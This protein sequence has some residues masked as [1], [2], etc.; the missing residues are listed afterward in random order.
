[1]STATLARTAV[2]PTRTLCA[3]S[4]NRIS[5]F[6][7]QAGNHSAVVDRGVDR[8]QAD[9]DST[10]EDFDLGDVVRHY[11]DNDLSA[12]E[13]ATKVRPEWLALL[14][15]IATGEVTHVLVWVLDRIIRDPNDLERLLNLCREHGTVIV[16]TAT[17]SVVDPNNP[18]SVMHARITG[19]VAAYESAKTS[20]RI[21]RKHAQMAVDGK[22]HG[23][24]RRF[25]Y[26]PGMVAVRESEAAV[27]RMLVGRL[28]AGESL[29]RLAA[30][31]TDAEVPTPQGGQWSGPNL[32]TML[33]RPH[34]A[35][36]RVHRGEVVGK[37]TWEPIITEAQH[38][39]VVALLSSPERK[40]STSNA[41]VYLLAGLAVCDECGSPL[42]GKPKTGRGNLPSYMC[43]TGRHTHRRVDLVDATVEAAIVARLER[44]DA[45]GLLVDDTEGEE[46]ARLRTA[47]AALD[48]RYADTVDEHVAGRMTSRAFSTTTARLEA[49]MDQ[50]DAAIRDAVAMAGRASAVLTGAVGDRAAE[51][52][53]SASLARRRALIDELAV[54]V[55]LRGGGR[56]SPEDVVIDWR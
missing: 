43:Q 19:A 49:D 13:F 36:L 44:T 30:D 38:A 51:A 27:V 14:E 39:Q 45:T 1:M 3:V 48:V 54:V 46:L 26:E 55:R 31:L 33:L 7:A 8:Q 10:A 47:R 15:H 52:W 53:A 21:R 12:S 32:R 2:R 37:G 29:Y 24:R 42:R 23:G 40:S 28:L 18:E 6:R 16:Q 35:G 17:G 41:R 11:V 25:G 20:M 5:K 4:Y 9:A 34:L 50:L 22:P 56:W